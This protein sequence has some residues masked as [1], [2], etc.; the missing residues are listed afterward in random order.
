MNIENKKIEEFLEN[1][2][3]NS[4]QTIKTSDDFTGLLMKRITA[5]NNLIADE[6]RNDKIARN[7]IISFVSLIVVML[8]LIVFSSGGN[9][10]DATNSNTVKIQPAVQ[11]SNDMISQMLTFFKNIFL[12]V[13]E[14]LGLNLS[15]NTFMIFL[16]I[17]AVVAVFMLVEKLVVRSKLKSSTES[18]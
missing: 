13:F 10:N 17:I 8:G 15:F 18:R 1:K 4:S 14:F 9:S 3:R 6:A 5:E 2:I 7:I 11:T 16:I 12:E